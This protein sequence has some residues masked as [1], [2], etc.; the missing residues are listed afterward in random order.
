MWVG[1]VN[2][3]LGIYVRHIFRRGC[4][5]SLRINRKGLGRSRNIFALAGT[6][7]DTIEYISSYIWSILIGELRVDVLNCSS[8]FFER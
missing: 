5:N 6:M 4:L 8:G 1:L 7:F 3:T 2:N